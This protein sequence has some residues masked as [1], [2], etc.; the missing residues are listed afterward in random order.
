MDYCFDLDGQENLDD[1][2]DAG[3]GDRYSVDSESKGEHICSSSL[4]QDGFSLG[5]SR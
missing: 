3:I 1:D 4:S 5:V 2:S